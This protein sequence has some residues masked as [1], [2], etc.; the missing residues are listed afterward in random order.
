LDEAIDR[1]SQPRLIFHRW[2]VGM[3]Q[4][5]ERPVFVGS[6][7]RFMQSLDIGPRRALGDPLSE[8]IDLGQAQ[9]LAFGRHAI[10]VVGRANTADQFALFG[11]AGNDGTRSRVRFGEQ[12][13][14]IIEA[15]A[16]VLL[17]SAVAFGT[18][19]PEDRFDVA[20]EVER[21][22]LSRGLALAIG[23]RLCARRHTGYGHRE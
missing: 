12:S 23:G 14:A 11:P 19:L 2:G 3:R 16:A 17:D 9:S 21:V 18:V 1:V 4:R 13:L 10:G 6:V 22:R 15:E 7:R 5:L 8:P 20:S